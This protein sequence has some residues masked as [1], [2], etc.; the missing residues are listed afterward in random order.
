MILLTF[1]VVCAAIC[2]IIAGSKNRSALGWAVLG[3]I[4]GVFALLVVACLGK[5]PEEGSAAAMALEAS[6][7]MKVCPQCA[8]TVKAA[9]KV[10]RYCGHNFV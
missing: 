6:E 7:P 8:E 4:F 10:C 1:W 5:L 2:A 3:A 9:A